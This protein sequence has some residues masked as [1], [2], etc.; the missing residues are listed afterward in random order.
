MPA[1][2]SMPLISIGNGDIVNT[3]RWSVS[4]SKE[5]LKEVPT[6]EIT[7]YQQ[8]LASIQQGVRYY[9]YQAKMARDNQTTGDPY[10]EMYSVQKAEKGNKYIFPFYNPFHHSI[11]NGWGESK[12]VTS[13]A[14]KTIEDGITTIA[15]TLLPAAGIESMKSWEGTTPMPYT[16]T[17][18]LL[19]TVTLSDI[20][21]NKKLINALINNNLMDKIDFISVR[22][23]AICLIKIPG[24]RK[25][26]VGVMSNILI[27]NLGQINVINNENIPDAYQISITIQELL[28]ESRQIWN[29]TLDEKVFTKIDI[30]PTD[31][32]D[33]DAM[34]TLV[35]TIF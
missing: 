6:I 16:F 20:E 13:T 15:T 4:T 2:R 1:I 19:N 24:V 18:Q 3:Y 27:E 34:K 9:K 33:V 22:P 21:K 23:P 35:D 10:M 25:K 32:M 8:N 26:T 14:V 31:S 5:A 17:F 11:T 29:N 30:D 12:G 28:T 7:E